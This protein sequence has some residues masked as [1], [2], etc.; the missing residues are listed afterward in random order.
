MTYRA[1]EKAR[2]ATLEGTKNIDNLRRRFVPLVKGQ[3]QAGAFYRRMFAGLFRYVSHRIPE[4]ADELYKIDDAM[5]AGFGWEM[6]P[7]ETWDA[8]GLASGVEMMRAEGQLPAP[9]VEQMVADG[10]ESF[11]RS[12]DGQKKYYDLEE[13]GYKVI[14]GTERLVLLDG[15]RTNHVV[16][17]NSD[18]TLFDLGDGV[19]GLEFHTKM[20]TL[21]AGVIEGINR[22]LTTAE[23]SFDGLVIGNEAVNF[24]AGANLA[25]VFMYAVEQEFDELDLMIRQFQNTI[26]RVR[27]SAVPVVV[28][29]RGLTLGGGCE[30][31]MHSDL[32]Q[33]TA[34]TYIGL[35]EVGV[36]VIPAGGGTKEFALRVSDGL[37]K[38]DVALNRLQNAFMDIAMAKVATSAHEA[39]TM[40]I[41]RPQDRISIN[42][43]RQL[44]DAKRAVTQLA[45]AGY[46]QPL[47]RTDV[48]V[49]GRSGMALFQAGI[50]AMRFGHYISAHDE[51]IAQKLAHVICGGDLSAPQP[52]SEKYLLDLE[53]EAFLSLCGERKTLERIQAVLTTGKPLRN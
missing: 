5:K 17:Q 30:L 49:Q 12:E 53:R 44:T 35:V 45:D 3:D 14:P 42:A 19:V 43:T 13:E 2:F 25:M 46:T 23:K 41:L 28:A 50:T 39:R 20:N 11:Y 37:E 9:W 47:P 29:P 40:G 21:G 16:W 36:G 15:L 27:Y 10:R 22:A 1:Q 34:E 26:M 7:F 31:T 52:V 18:S 6:G 38:G 8:I 4:I 24:S 33:A 48:V 32:A 51:K